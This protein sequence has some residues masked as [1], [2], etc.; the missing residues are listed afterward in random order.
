MCRPTSV[1]VCG[2]RGQLAS[3]TLFGRLLQS[4]NLSYDAP[5]QLSGSNR[6]RSS[7]SQTDRSDILSSLDRVAAARQHLHGSERGQY[8]AALLIATW[9]RNAIRQASGHSPGDRH[10]LSTAS[11]SSSSWRTHVFSP[12]RCS[13]VDNKRCSL[14]GRRRR[15]CRR[16]CT[17]RE[18]PTERE[19]EY[20]K[21]LLC[22]YQPHQSS[23]S[24]TR[25]ASPREHRTGVSK[26]AGSGKSVNHIAEGKVSTSKIS[27]EFLLSRL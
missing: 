6:P 4:R 27:H 5:G 8:P 17:R 19:R 2:R 18:K 13:L 7:I 1:S 10:P 23:S 3:D 12:E 14:C 11:S 20:A 22:F 26:S 15:R 16:P 25:S 9:S 24:R 21:L